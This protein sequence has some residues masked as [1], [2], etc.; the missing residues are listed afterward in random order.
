[1]AT[2]FSDVGE[3]DITSSLANSNYAIT[4]VGDKL[5][6]GQRAITL[7]ATDLSKI[8]Q[9]IDPTLAY[10][11]T[12]GSIVN[13]DNLGV[14]LTRVT[15]EDVNSTG[16]AISNNGTF[17]SNYDV[18]FLNGKLNITPKNLN[19]QISL[20]TTETFG[21]PVKLDG[22]LTNDLISK[23]AKIVVLDGSNND[24]SELA[25]QG[26]IQPGKYIVKAINDNS[27]Y[28]FSSNQLELTINPAIDPTTIIKT[29]ISQPIIPSVINPIVVA[30]QT[31]PTISNNLALQL[32]ITDSG[33]VSL[34]SQTI[35]GQANQVVTLSE[36]RTQND[37][38]ENTNVQTQDVRVSLNGNSIIEL[39]NGGVSLPD[40][41]DQEFY[42]VSNENKKE[43]G[44]N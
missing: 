13:N 32:G 20:K 15:G 23:G 40:G 35:Q 30:P 41:V 31:L 36:L 29:Q 6:I 38:S 37:S 25:K 12:N 16:Y 21:I 14:N 1:T 10:T 39:V 19:A 43:N 5:T 8:Y 42:I 24:V 4:Y 33:S 44:A 28:D 11:V 34:V 7:K 3:Y 9:E 2:Q 22:I 26:R 18:T 27:N 17:N